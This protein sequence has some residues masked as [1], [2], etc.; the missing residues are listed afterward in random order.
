MTPSNGGDLKER[1]MKESN[2]LGKSYTW[3]NFRPGEPMNETVE[4]P[5]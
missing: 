3:E 5:Y 4:I 2:L 1:R